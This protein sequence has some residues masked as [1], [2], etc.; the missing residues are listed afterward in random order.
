MLHA[1]ASPESPIE[2]KSSIKGGGG[3]RREWCFYQEEEERVLGRIAEQWLLSVLHIF[4]KFS[5]HCF[6]KEK[7]IYPLAVIKRGTIS[8]F[9]Y[10]IETQFPNI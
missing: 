10:F 4:L 9:K 6:L 1:V 5:F 2:T 8:F 3:D 7:D